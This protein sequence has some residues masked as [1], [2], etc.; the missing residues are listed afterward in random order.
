M[1]KKIYFRFLLSIF[2]LS[3]IVNVACLRSVSSE[4]N[5]LYS[6]PTL[7]WTHLKN[8]ERV[9]AFAQAI[10]R[11]RSDQEFQEK[12]SEE[13]RLSFLAVGDIMAHLPVT[14]SAKQSDGNYNFSSH[15]R[16]VQ[17]T[18]ASA[19]LAFAN[20]ET[21][22]AE[23]RKVSGYPCFNAPKELVSD[24]RN[25][26]FD[27]IGTANNHMLDQS[28]TGYFDTIQ[29][30]RD[31]NLIQVGGRLNTTEDNYKIVEKNGLKIGLCAY[32]YSY[33]GFESGV[34]EKRDLLSHIDFSRIQNDFQAL[35]DHQTDFNI[36]FLHWGV[37]YQIRP[38]PEERKLAQAIADLGFDLIVG[39]HPHVLQDFSILQS[40]ER[41]VPVIYSLGNF[42]SNQRREN[43]GVKRSEDGA[44]FLC[45][46]V[47]KGEN[48]LI[49]NVRFVP[50]WVE[51]KQVGQKSEFTI[52]PVKAFLESRL[53]ADSTPDRLVKIKESEAS[54]L[55]V[56]GQVRVE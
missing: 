8:Q 20:L 12:I 5:F 51:K 18:I 9:N 10:E 13:K 53:D 26:G 7:K 41:K 19:D 30:I 43:M 1:L 2:I 37:E 3:L 45:E 17:S 15:Y 38:R 34:G 47:K 24:L 40:G 16:Y 50:T 21:P 55:K 31:E 52:F 4:K 11:L 35:K 39:S 6:L 44:M 22:I 14:L 36:I 46:L 33:N 27:I 28:L 54:T 56:L 23:G 25:V 48:R 42:I 29:H 32:T 49:E